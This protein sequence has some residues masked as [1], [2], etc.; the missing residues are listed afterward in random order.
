MFT[1][2]KHWCPSFSHPK[3]GYCTRVLKFL[4]VFIRVSSPGYV[5]APPP[6]SGKGSKQCM[7][8]VTFSMVWCNQRQN[9]D[10]H[11]GL[12]CW[13]GCGQVSANFLTSLFKLSWGCGPRWK[14]FIM[15]VMTGWV[16]GNPQIDTSGKSFWTIFCIKHK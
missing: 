8:T 3:I 5:V 13:V 16:A 1:G 7:I 12:T 9:Q 15:A 4:F 11:Q 2:S 14:Y 6:D 10:N